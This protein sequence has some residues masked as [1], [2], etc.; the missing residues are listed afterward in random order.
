MAWLRAH[1]LLL[2]VYAGALGL[3][4]FELANPRIQDGRPDAPEVYLDPETNIADVS[5]AVWPDRALSLYYR[6]YQAALCGE[7]AGETHDACRARGPV[8]PGEIRELLER[9]LATGNRSIELAM[10]NYAIVLL[11]ENA[12][13]QDVDAAIRRWRAAHP[14]SARPDPRRVY[15]EMQQ[16]RQP[17]DRARS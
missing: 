4:I 11:Q 3:G 12:A 10:Y 15:R 7:R 17:A 1:R 9:A 6:A 14:S 8:E 13:P 2:I 16:R 5:A